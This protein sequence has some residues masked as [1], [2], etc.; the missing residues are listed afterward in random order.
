MTQEQLIEAVA[1][2]SGAKTAVVMAV[3]GPVLTGWREK[4][5]AILVAF[6]PGE[7]ARWKQARSS[8]GHCSPCSPLQRW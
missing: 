2:K 8:G 4:V 1:A 3:P 7:A 6:L 5:A